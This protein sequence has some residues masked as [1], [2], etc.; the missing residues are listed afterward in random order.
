MLG[1]FADITLKFKDD[2][3]NFLEN[4]EHIQELRTKIKEAASF[5][6]HSANYYAAK[7]G[8]PVKEIDPVIKHNDGTF[9]VT[10]SNKG[11]KLK[12]FPLPSNEPGQPV[13]LEITF[14]PLEL[15]ISDE[16]LE[17]SITAKEFKAEKQK[18]MDYL[19]SM[20]FKS[21]LALLEELRALG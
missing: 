9:S 4:N 6:S 17:S 11:N 8:T 7:Q 12:L 21:Y 16:Y 1:C 3:T 2:P 5:S 10:L 14:E 13:L 15:S 20:L 18:M 19:N